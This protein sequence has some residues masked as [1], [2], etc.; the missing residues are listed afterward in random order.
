[1]L[2]MYIFSL[3]LSTNPYSGLDMTSNDNTNN[4]LV[5]ADYTMRLVK[6]LVFIAVPIIAII[7]IYN[8]IKLYSKNKI[9]EMIT[10]LVFGCLMCFIIAN[11]SLF[12]KIGESICSFIG[13]IVSSGLNTNINTNNGGMEL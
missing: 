8:T 13:S 12:Y 3:L 4:M 11:P 1:M 2:K 6:S 5:N 7:T 10:T 9:P